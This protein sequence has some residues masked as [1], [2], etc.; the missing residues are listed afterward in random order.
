MTG[1]RMAFLWF[2]VAVLFF[3]AAMIR[4]E[5]RAVYIALGVVFIILAGNAGRKKGGG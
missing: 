4:E 5:E 1:A 3:L 2:I